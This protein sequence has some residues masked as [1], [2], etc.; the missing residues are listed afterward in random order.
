MLGGEGEECW[1]VRVR[2]LGGEGEGCWEVRISS[3]GR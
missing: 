3:A 1:E 2:V